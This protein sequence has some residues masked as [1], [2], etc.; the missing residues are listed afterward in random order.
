[1][2]TASLTCQN[3]TN[4]QLN[5]F[6]NAVRTDTTEIPDF[7]MFIPDWFPFIFGVW[8]AWHS[9]LDVFLT[10]GQVVNNLNPYH[11]P[12]NSVSRPDPSCEHML[13]WWRFAVTGLVYFLPQ[14]GSYR[15]WYPSARR[16]TSR[17]APC[18]TYSWSKSTPSSPR[19]P[20]PYPTTT[21]QCWTM[22]ASK[23]SFDF[24]SL[25]LLHRL[26]FRFWIA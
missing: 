15:A 25:W 2:V 12:M 24:E 3:Q 4:N 19:Q 10:V 5:S 16:L 17:L 8:T 11:T 14:C 6:N 1:M 9:T 18:H 23:A 13:L 26:E 22:Y 20:K 7:A 21:K